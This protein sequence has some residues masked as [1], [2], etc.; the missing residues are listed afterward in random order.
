MGS[1][2]GR[3][4]A[5]GAS[6]ARGHPPRL[7]ARSHRGHGRR[8]RRL[9]QRRRLQ[10]HAYRRAVLPDERPRARKSPGELHRLHAGR[11]L[12]RLRQEAPAHRAR[13]GVRGARRKRAA[14]VLLGRG[15]AGR[16]ARLLRPPRQLPRRIVRPRRVRP[17]RH[18]RQRLGVDVD[19]VR[20]PTPTRPPPARTTSTAAGAGAGASP[21][22]S[23]PRCETATSPTNGAPRSA[24]AA[25]APKPPS[26]AP[27]TPKP[28]ARRASA[29]KATCSAKKASR[30][31][32][33]PAPP[34]A[35]PCPA[36]R[37]A[38]ETKSHD[39]AS[40]AAAAAE[41]P[42]AAPPVHRTRTPGNDDDCKTR[43][44]GKPAAYRYEGGTFY[45]RNPVIAGDGCTKRDMGQTWTSACCSG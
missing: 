31:T 24:S 11:G 21:S 33:R 35:S 5:R 34:A 9:R 42:A 25:P 38:L 36:Q 17:A 32:A 40:A 18:V 12:L 27:K 10:A 37:V 16:E 13:V 7:P 3:G 26:P 45:S 8:L 28:A 19:V 6:R 22:G 1:R 23:A 15:A 43:Y 41:A 39:P 4:F 30:G 2:R 14:Q 44:I 29:S 20:Q